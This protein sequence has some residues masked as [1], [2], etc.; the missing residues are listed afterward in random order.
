MA[1]KITIINFN[2]VIAKL[3]EYYFEDECYTS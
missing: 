3:H 2:T 1:I